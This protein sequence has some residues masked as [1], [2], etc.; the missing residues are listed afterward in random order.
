[1]SSKN[2]IPKGITFTIIFESSALNRDEK[3]GG[4]IPSIKKLNRY[5]NST[6]GKTY[7]YI[8]RESIRHHLFHTLHMLDQNTWKLTPTSAQNDVVQF[9]LTKANILDFSEIDAF[10]YMYTIAGSNAITRKAPVGI[11]KAVALEAWEGDMQFNAN[12]DLIKRTNKFFLKEGEKEATPNPVNKEEH[13]TYYKASITIDT[14]RLCYDEWPIT[15]YVYNEQEKELILYLT[16]KDM[17]IKLGDVTKDDDGFSIKDKKISITGSICSV[18]QD[19]MEEKPK[20]KNSDEKYLKFK[21]KFIHQEENTNEDDKKKKPKFEVADYTTNIIDDE[22]CYKFIIPEYKYDGSKQTLKLSTAQYHHKIDNV[23]SNGDGSY[24]V[25][26]EGNVRIDNKNKVVFEVDQK[27]KIKRAKSIINAVK[28]GLL[29]HV[30]GEN[31]GII[32]KF[33]I[34]AGLKLPVP[35]FQSYIELDDFKESILNN[36]YILKTSNSKQFL[37]IEDNIGLTEPEILEKALSWEDFKNALFP[38][39]TPNSKSMNNGG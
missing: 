14:E 32:P 13:M 24:K 29:F 37:Y 12:H 1:M 28:N 21:K 4:N 11:T 19:L 35:L 17:E 10:G 8:S 25:K 33:I 18:H 31:Y 16:K 2:E 30:S 38:N 23:I 9:D 27:E 36:E 26:D 34:A 6:K 22:K 5:A 7:S 15:D 39:S 3:I 20:K